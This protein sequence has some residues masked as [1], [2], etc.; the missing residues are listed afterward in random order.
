[1]LRLTVI[2]DT[3]DARGENAAFGNYLIDQVEVLKIKDTEIRA[4][5]F[6]IEGGGLCSG[7]FERRL[8]LLIRRFFIFSRLLFNYSLTFA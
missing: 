2:L 3:Q 4:E 7:R 8:F 1:M 6:S 5:Y